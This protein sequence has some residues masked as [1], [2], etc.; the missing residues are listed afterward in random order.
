MKDKMESEPQELKFLTTV[1]SIMTLVQQKSSLYWC[2]SEEFSSLPRFR[3]NQI[4]PGDS[5]SHS[6]ELVGSNEQLHCQRKETF[7]DEPLP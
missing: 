3:L 4:H 6:S 7:L 2:D 1:W 5:F